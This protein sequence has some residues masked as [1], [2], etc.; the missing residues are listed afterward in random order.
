MAAIFLTLY[1]NENVRHWRSLEG[2]SHRVHALFEAL[3]HNGVALERYLAF[4]YHI[5][6]QSLPDAFARVAQRLRKGGVKALVKNEESM[7]LLEVLLQRYVYGRPAE[8]KADH[9]MQEAVLYLL[10]ALVEGGSSAAFRMRDDFVTPA[11]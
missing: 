6:E 3:P 2:H 11:V 1:W 10:D 5:G 8:L 9:R 7:F 4:L